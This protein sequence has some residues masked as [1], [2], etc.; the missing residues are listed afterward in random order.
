MNQLEPPHIFEVGIFCLLLHT[1]QSIS[2]KLTTIMNKILRYSIALI[3]AFVAVGCSG[4]KDSPEPAT[5]QNPPT[6]EKLEIKISPSLSGTRATDYGFESGDCIGL[7]VV[8]YTE[9]N[10]GTLSNS[11]NH[12]NNMRFSYNGI[13]TP[14][15]QV[16]WGDNETHADF[17]V[18]YPYSSV[19]SVNAHEF[20]VKADQS[21]ESAYK[22]SDLMTGKTLN[23]APTSSAIEIP[24]T[25]AMS[26]ASIYL[27]AGN[28]FTAESLSKANI[29]VR[30]NG[31]KCNSTINLAT[32][33]VTPVGEAAAITP[34]FSGNHYMALIVPQTVETNNLITVTVDGRD[35]NLQKGFTFESGKN[36][37]FTITLSKTSAGVNVNITPWIDDETDNGGT[38]E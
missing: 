5:P 18:Y 28:G 37:N 11:G 21:T 13:W 9:G 1:N 36:H 30:I 35:F 20:A 16:T 33:E 25:H 38:A 27:E 17:Y 19:K 3:P 24:V 32:G 6:Q 22:A 12:V 15:S 26:R 8:N 2:K 31:V 34:L 14:D 7:Y 29:S 23:V 10:P 4:G